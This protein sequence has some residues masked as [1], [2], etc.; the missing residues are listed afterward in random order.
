MIAQ[1]P[2]LIDSTLET[3]AE[4]TAETGKR[5]REQ[6]QADIQRN[7]RALRRRPRN[8]VDAIELAVQADPLKAVAATLVIGIIIGNRR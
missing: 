5:S 1:Q 7:L 6:V 4:V 2:D 3:I 8:I